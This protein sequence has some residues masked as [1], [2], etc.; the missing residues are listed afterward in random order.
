MKIN[1]TFHNFLLYPG[2]LT[3][4]LPTKCLLVAASVIFGVATLGAF[5]LGAF[6]LK[7]RV[8]KLSKLPQ[9]EKI[10]AASEKVFN[11]ESKTKVSSVAE[12]KSKNTPQL[13]CRASICITTQTGGYIGS[14][15]NR[16]LFPDY[17]KKM[18]LKD[19][20]P[21]PLEATDFVVEFHRFNPSPFLQAISLPE[22]FFLPSKLLEGKKEGDKLQLK[23]EGQP[24]E[25]TINQENH[26][27]KFVNGSFKE[28]LDLQ[29]A[30]IQT[31]CDQENPCFSKYNPF[32]GY[33]LEPEG[34]L[35]QPG[36]KETGFNPKIQD[37]NQFRH[38]HDPSTIVKYDILPSRDGRNLIF[39]I[40][41]PRFLPEDIQLIVNKTHLN[42]Y[43]F[44]ENR[45]LLPEEALKSL[46]LDKQEALSSSAEFLVSLRWDRHEFFK[47]LSLDQM[48]GFVQNGHFHFLNGII[49]L[50]LPLP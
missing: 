38:L 35:Y 2:K 36:G 31:T 6:C 25:L 17:L 7:G 10:N 30:Y 37:K 33:R 24:L 29:R 21:L 5:H 28:A 3:K 15:E 39:L 27:L 46:P 14:S 43:G 47:D 49:Q 32:W 44:F 11:A 12:I 26:G 1:L 19:G 45:P 13:K 50:D 4:S 34:I 8:N 41:A 22:T 23:Y 20:S 40:E 16:P 42:V 18:T 9:Q 48:K